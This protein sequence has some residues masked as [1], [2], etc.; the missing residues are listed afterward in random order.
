MLNTK[1]NLGFNAMDFYF[2]WIN[3]QEAH[4]A[5]IAHLFSPPKF[6]EGFCYTRDFIWTNL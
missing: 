4:G 2:G 5:C 3:K 1:M 6:F